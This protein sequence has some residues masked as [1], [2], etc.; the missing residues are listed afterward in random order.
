MV[1]K[2]SFLA[3]F[4]GSCFM[5]FGQEI[6]TDF[7]A[8]EGAPIVTKGDFLIQGTV[9]VKYIGSGGHVEITS[10]LELTEIGDNAFG[11]TQVESVII[12][13]GL[14]KIG[15]YAFMN[16]KTLTGITIP[17]S[18]TSIGEGGFSRCSQLERIDIPARVASI[19]GNI[20]ADCTGLT[21]ITVAQNNRNYSSIEGVL[22]NKNGTVL[23][24]YPVGKEDAAYTVPSQVNRIEQSAFSNGFHLVEVIFPEGLTAIGDRAFYNCNSLTSITIPLSLATIG[25]RAFYRCSNLAALTLPAGLK[26]IGNYAFAECTSLDTI[27]LSRT[28]EYGTDPFRKVPGTLP[29]IP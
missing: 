19:G 29:Y 14:T 27:L 15:S 5:L 23:I 21:A 11:N 10:D 22:F 25:D 9:L 17:N 20:F 24:A 2:I 12:P 18:V 26:R 8:P 3:L 6:I 16:C 28:T 4:L 1:R 7:T 13:E